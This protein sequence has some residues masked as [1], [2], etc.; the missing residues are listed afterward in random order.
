[1]PVFN[2]VPVFGSAEK[3]MG[4]LIKCGYDVNYELRATEGEVRASLGRAPKPED[5]ITFNEAI[6]NIM[7]SVKFANLEQFMEFAA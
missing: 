1:V 7:L 3:F 5:E 6:D 4:D 2:G